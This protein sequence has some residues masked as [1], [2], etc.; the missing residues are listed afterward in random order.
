MES[1]PLLILIQPII[2]A[3][4]AEVKDGSKQYMDAKAARRMEAFSQFAVAA[5]KEA[6]EQ[7]GIDME[8]ED[9]YRGM[10]VGSASASRPWKR[11]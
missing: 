8:K 9:P 6:L 10:C 2:S 7:S 5:S 4:I 3:A 11:M 1:A